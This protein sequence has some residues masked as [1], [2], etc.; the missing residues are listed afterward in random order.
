MQ[1]LEYQEIIDALNQIL[2]EPYFSHLAYDPS[3][4]RN[5]KIEKIVLQVTRVTSDYVQV[6]ADANR[7][8]SRLKE[9]TGRSYKAYAAVGDGTSPRFVTLH[10]DIEKSAVNPDTGI[11][12]NIKLPASEPVRQMILELDYP[13]DGIRVVVATEAL[14]GKFQ[15]SDEQKRAKNRGNLNVFRYDVV[16][17]QFKW[18]LREGELGQP[19]GPRT[20]YFLAKGVVA[21]PAIETVERTALSPNTGEEYQITLPATSVVKQAL[22]GFDY[23][24][25]GIRIKDVAEALADQFGLTDEQRNAK[26]SSGLVWRHHVNVTANDLVKAGKLLRIRIGWIINPEQLDIETAE[27][28]DDA[29]PFSGGDTPSPEVV[30]EQNYREHRDGLKE[31]L[32]QKIMDNPPDFFEKLVLDLLVK[33]GYGNSSADTEVLGRSGDGGIDGIIKED[34]LGL[35]LIYIQAKR[36]QGSVSVHLV[37]DFT[38]AL[39]CKGAQKGIFIATSDFT[40]DTKKFV[41]EVRSRRI[42]LIDGKRL[43]QLMIDHELGVSSGNSYHLKEVD[44]DYFTI[45]DA[46]DDD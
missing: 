12:E 27:D 18:L 11:E 43:V 14:A 46:V 42:I 36:Q 24:A 29:S 35:D 1:P 8:G 3:D 16:A 15:L 38:G 9:T 13:D 20:P 30:I 28:S 6:T 4:P 2:T 34:E 21:P 5:G 25:S 31:E 22:L 40:R 33:M 37:R 45:D 17:P 7:I 39:D 41:E 44:L 23:P 10:E 19:G 26:F 32:L